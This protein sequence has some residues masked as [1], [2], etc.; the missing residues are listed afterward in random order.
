MMVQANQGEAVLDTPNMFIEKRIRPMLLSDCANAFDSNAYSFALM[1]NGIRCIAYLDQNCTEL[2]SARNMRL[3]PLFPELSNLHYAAMRCCIID[4]FIVP[5]EKELPPLDD[6]HSRMWITIPSE[7]NKAAK[8]QPVK[9]IAHDLLY[10][11][12]DVLVDQQYDRRRMLLRDALNDKPN[13]AIAHVMEELGIAFYGL[14]AQNGW[15]GI[16]ARRKD[17][18]Y[19]AG[20]NPQDWLYIP[21]HR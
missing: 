13:I 3:L 17:G 14:A 1:Q 4:G 20:K 8:E 21:V 7:I 12:G 11:D 6:V 2:R 18:Q 10:V 19:R 15:D 5:D 9:F 16:I